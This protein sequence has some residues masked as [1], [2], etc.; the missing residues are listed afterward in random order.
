[1]G[2]SNSAIII[3]LYLSS[4]LAYLQWYGNDELDIVSIFP[5]L[6]ISVC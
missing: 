2:S 1:M 3:Y 5:I 6:R 4:T